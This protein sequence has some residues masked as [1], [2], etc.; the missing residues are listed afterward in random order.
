MANWKKR[1]YTVTFDFQ[2]GVTQHETR[3][4]EYG[5]ELGNLP[6]SGSKKGYV[7]KGWYTEPERG[8]RISS[9]TIVRNNVTYYAHWE[10][11]LVTITYHRNPTKVN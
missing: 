2:D 4:Y 5:E 1:K 8:K 3:E 11:D 7:I 9:E 6:T 10:K